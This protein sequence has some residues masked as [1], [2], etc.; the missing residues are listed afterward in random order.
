MRA[1]GR[2]PEGSTHVATCDLVHAEVELWRLNMARL[3]KPWQKQ[4]YVLICHFDPRHTPVSWSG[5]DCFMCWTD[6]YCKLIA[7]V[8]FFKKMQ[9]TLCDRAEGVVGGRSRARG[10]E[11]CRLSW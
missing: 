6:R 1:E 8:F 11:F 4:L 7:A 2:L 3:P 10:C 5:E 9:T